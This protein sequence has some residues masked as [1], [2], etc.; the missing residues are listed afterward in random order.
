MQF[1]MPTRVIKNFSGDAIFNKVAA[2]NFLIISSHSAAEV[3]GAL[4][5]VS[6]ALKEIGASFLYD[7]SITPN[8][9]VQSIDHLQDKYQSKSISGIIS[10]GGGS[11]IDAA[12][13]LSLCLANNIN[14]SQLLEVDYSQFPKLPHI[15]IPTTCGTGSETSKGAIL[16]NYENEWKGGV[17]GENIFCDVAVLEPKYLSSLSLEL[18]LSTGFDAI[19]HAIETYVSKASSPMT[20]KLSFAALDLLV[21]ALVKLAS[22]GDKAF[23]T[24]KDKEDLLLG[25]CFA[26]MNLANSSTCLPHRL[27]YCIGAITDTAHVDGVALLYPAWVKNLRQ[28][29]VISLAEINKYLAHLQPELQSTEPILDLLDL[30]AMKKE[31]SDLGV[32]YAMKDKLISLASGTLDLDPGYLGAQTIEQIFEETLTCKQ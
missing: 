22:H 16:S 8:P 20:K 1:F 23:L 26:G 7:N 32:S 17:R 21:P 5:D 11:V 14:C 24:L 2:D 25:S 19:S 29:K 10:I 15:S 12:K 13:V 18:Y 31:A 28:N 4:D 9:T 3:S 27:Q 30:L 6:Q